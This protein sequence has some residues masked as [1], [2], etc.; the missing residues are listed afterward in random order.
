MITAHENLCRVTMK[1]V[2]E[3][4]PFSGFRWLKSSQQHG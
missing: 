1:N 4:I 3:Q 2:L